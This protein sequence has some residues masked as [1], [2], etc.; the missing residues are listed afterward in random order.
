[1]TQFVSPQTFFFV[2]FYVQS[3][4]ELR[5]EQEVECFNGVILTCKWL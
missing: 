4:T 1:M 2:S 5:C 3:P